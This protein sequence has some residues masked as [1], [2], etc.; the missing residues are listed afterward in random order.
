M[1]SVAVPVSRRIRRLLRALLLATGFGVLFYL[2]TRHQHAA[3]PQFQGTMLEVGNGVRVRA[4]AAGA[5]DTTLVFLHGY[6]ESL[7]AWS[8][9]LDH[10]TAH[11]RVLA[12]DLPGFGVSDPLPESAAYDA[13]LQALETLIERETSGPVV[14]V[15][16]SM[17]GELAA[18]LALA[19]PGRVVAAILIAPAG[20][21]LNGVFGDSGVVSPWTYW[22]AEAVPYVIPIHD[23]LWLGEPSGPHLPEAA[24]DSIL[25]ASAR[26]VLEEFDFAA[27]GAR[28]SELRQPV[29]LIWGRQDPTIP[30][31]VG[32]RIAS[33]LPCRRYVV[34]PA[35]HRPHQTLPVTVITEMERFLRHPVACG[36]R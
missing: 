8:G 11:Y 6:G 29:L 34:L 16:H 1:W 14:V 7:L 26:R 22:V 4:L 24:R 19:D 9:L 32:D 10:F 33:L 27:I 18:G 23:T 30:V 25:R 17:G 3:A 31:A 35:L 36:Q 2:T 21:G 5:G 15:G 13:Y 12:I 20:A 28:F